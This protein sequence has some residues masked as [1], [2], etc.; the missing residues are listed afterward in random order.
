[1]LRLQERRAQQA[2][3]AHVLSAAHSSVARSCAHLLRA[4]LQVLA[5][6]GLVDEHAGALNHKVHAELAPRQLCRV[7]LAHNADFLAVDAD[8][9]VALDLQQWAR[10][11]CRMRCGCEDSAVR[12][13]CALCTAWVAGRMLPVPSKSRS[14]GS[15]GVGAEVG[16]TRAQLGDVKHIVQD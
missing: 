10:Q 16:S 4:G 14:K 3:V 2:T 5:R 12:A 9:V 11:W 7:T 13:C 15:L 6:A 1:M 8:A